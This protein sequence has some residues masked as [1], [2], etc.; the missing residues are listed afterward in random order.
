MSRLLFLTSQVALKG[1][2]TKFELEKLR[3]LSGHGPFPVRYHPRM[4][5]ELRGT[6]SAI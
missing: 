5:D 6:K 1:I 4:Y 3:G 2:V